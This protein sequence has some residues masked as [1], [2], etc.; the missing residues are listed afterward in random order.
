MRNFQSIPIVIKNLLIANG[1]MYLAEITFGESFINNLALHNYQSDS[2]GIWQLITYQFLHA[3]PPM[4]FH[5]LFNML[6]LWMFGSVLETLWGAK[7]FILFYLICGIG[8]GLINMMAGSIEL[9]ILINKVNEGKIPLS[10][11]QDR[12]GSI[13]HGVTLGASGSIMGVFAAYAYLFPNNPMYIMP[14]PFPIKTK[15]VIIG[16]I[17][18]DVFGGINP[19]YG[20]GVAHYA[21]L[22]GALFGFILVKTMNKTNRRNF[23]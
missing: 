9:N 17:L 8:A 21:H 4:I 7:R 6:A 20:G 23:Y 10:Y 3:M 5:L 15:Y 13:V 11:F 1:L 14:F 18:L 2:F 12:A 22:G 16:L 19:Q